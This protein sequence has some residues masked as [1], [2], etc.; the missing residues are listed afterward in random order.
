[1]FDRA[2][3]LAKLG[4]WEIDL[5]T[6]VTSWS[7][8]MYELH[9]V[10]RSFDFQSNKFLQFYPEPDRTRLI[11]VL[12]KSRK[13]CAPYKFEGRMFSKQGQFR[14]VR[15]VGDVET[16]AGVPVRRF[17]LWQD[18]S[19]EKSMVDQIRN[20]ARRDDLTGL[21]NRRAL[22]DELAVLAQAGGT[23]ARAIG[24]LSLDI[25]RF[26]EINEAQGAVA[27][28][29]CL[30]AIGRRIQVAAG[31]SSIVARVG[32]DEF[33]I[34]VHGEDGELSIDAIARRILVA[35]AEPIQWKGHSFQLTAS[36]GTAV[37]LSANGVVPED[38]IGDA[39]LA[40]HDAK[41]A[42]KS[43]Q[44]KFRPELQ[45]MS[46]ERLET[47]RDVRHAL[48]IRHLELYYQ[49]KVCLA[50]G[51]HQGFEA[52]LR[53]NKSAQTVVAPGSFPAALEDAVLSKDIGDFVV[54]SA[55]E[56][57]DQWKRRNIPFGHIA[58]N[59][60][61]SQFWDADIAAKLLATLKEY[62]VGP[63]M[64]AVEV[65]ENVLLSNVSENVLMAC[66]A[67]K[68]GG[69]KIA[70]D[71]FGTGYASLSHLQD[72]PVDVIKI[73][74]SFVSKLHK[75]ENTT[76]IVNAIVGLAHSLSKEVVAEGVEMESQASFLKA[77]GCD[78]GQGYLF[79]RPAPA[80]LAA[81][82]L[83]KQQHVI[84]QLA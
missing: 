50:D 65:T 58:I 40:L 19:D 23:S 9:G 38:L 56:Q 76:V 59:L 36:I 6:G 45:I 79:G 53:W 24:L 5:S 63:S 21:F 64:I 55:I 1:M 26:K 41:A 34:L 51:S 11:E 3:V 35:V 84:A 4:A 28:D 67:F 32:G 61:A 82:H 8:G 80:N 22:G 78:Q 75:G 44:R 66:R 25:D 42:G 31:D 16:V 13:D 74:R 52:L 27:G 17:G 37:Q 15:I 47:L 81:C 54:L 70:F 33:T 29:F 83:M 48:A 12:E 2:S 71:D 10:D 46:K 77:I 43:C 49:P 20:L 30:I 14:W 62:G 57:A 7:E 39:Q 73:D 18:I 68:A 72:F 60:S 69:V